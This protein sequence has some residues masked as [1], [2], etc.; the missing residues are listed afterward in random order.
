MISQLPSLTQIDDRP[1]FEE[2]RRFA[3]AFSKGGRDAEKE[4]RKQWDEE[5]K[6]KQ[7]QYLRDFDNMIAKS[8]ARHRVEEANKPKEDESEQPADTLKEAEANLS[9]D[10]KKKIHDLAFSHTTTT[11]EYMELKGG[12]LKEKESQ[13]KKE[14]K[15]KQ[16]PKPKDDDMIFTA[17]DIEDETG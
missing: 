3:E 9:E 12:F 2:E 10:Q 11:E 4:E 16:Q 7:M 6:E 15:A 5:R 17:D 8:R 14:A 1:V 13:W